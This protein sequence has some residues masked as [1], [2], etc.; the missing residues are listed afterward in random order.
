MPSSGTGVSPGTTR[1]FTMVSAAKATGSGLVRVE[2]TTGVNAVPGLI[3][4]VGEVAANGMLLPD[5]ACDG[6]LAAETDVP[7]R[8][9]AVMGRH[10]RNH[11]R[12]LASSL[13]PRRTAK[14]R[15]ILR[16][17]TLA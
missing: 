9:A 12:I 5:A 2:T 3:P 8:M 13:P 15:T 10:I 17:S 6:L 7:I 16:F 14:R 4:G 1:R 11:G